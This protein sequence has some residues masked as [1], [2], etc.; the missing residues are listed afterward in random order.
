MYFYAEIFSPATY[1]PSNLDFIH[2]ISYKPCA[3]IKQFSGTSYAFWL[4]SLVASW[5][6]LKKFLYVRQIEV[7]CTGNYSTNDR[8]MF[9][10]LI[11]LVY[12]TT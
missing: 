5:F 6:V 4:L 11:S 1:R 12:I 9:I 3:P 8:V 10:S 2:A 7:M